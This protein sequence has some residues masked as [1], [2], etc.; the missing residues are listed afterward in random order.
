METKR[1]RFIRIAESRT[2]KIINMIN[3]LGNCSNTSVY[4]YGTTDVDEIFNAIGMELDKAKRKFSRSK[5]VKSEKF[6][7]SRSKL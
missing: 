6:K 5:E 7:L 1:D 4:E 2:N 3:L